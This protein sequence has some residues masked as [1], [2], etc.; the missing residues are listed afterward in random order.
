VDPGA[1]TEDAGEVGADLAGVVV[2]PPPQAASPSISGRANAATHL[3]R[4]G[5][6]FASKDPCLSKDP[7]LSQ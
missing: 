3:L 6:L 4:M 7:G 1:G 2:P 5:A